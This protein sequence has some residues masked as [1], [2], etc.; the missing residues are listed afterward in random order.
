VAVRIAV[1]AGTRAT[2][3]GWSGGDLEPD[4]PVAVCFGFPDQTT[5]PTE[6]YAES[7]AGDLYPES[8]DQ[9]TRINLAFE[10][11]EEL[12]LAPGQSSDLIRRAIEELPGP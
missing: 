12:A 1:T 4:D 7:I 2:Y 6:V 9:I 11:I 8:A 10:R 3:P 5:F